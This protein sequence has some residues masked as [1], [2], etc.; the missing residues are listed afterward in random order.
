MNLNSRIYIAGS[1]TLVGL[2]ITRALCAQGYRHVI[3]D[4]PGER[5]ALEC[6]FAEHQPEYVFHAAG[7]CGGIRANQSFPADLCQDNLQVTSR[8]LDAA[9]RYGVRRL[10]YL[11]S[12]CC[13]PRNAPQPLAVESLWS[14][15]LEPT[16]EAYA[17]AKLAGIALCRAYRQQYGC[18]FVVGIPTNAFGPGDDFDPDDGHVIASLMARLH[19]AKELDEPRVTIWGSGKPVRQFLYVDDLADA[20]LHVMRLEP[21]VELIN[22]AGGE[23]L[24]IAELATKIRDVVGY[25]GRLDFDLSRPDGMPLKSLD[26]GPL[27]ATGWSTGTQ[28]DVALAATYEWYLSVAQ[29]LAHVG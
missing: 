15:P 6:I 3:T 22:L 29:E 17:T 27:A 16:N 26:G 10:L 28:F 5:D 11:A 25:H 7:R 9:H 24:S 8:L 13:Y 19:E 2:A 23:S 14:G 21:G 20:C 12:A 1:D 4:T 18:D